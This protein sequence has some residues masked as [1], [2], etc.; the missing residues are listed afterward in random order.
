MK[1]SELIE[2]Y[3]QNKLDEQKMKEVGAE[4]EKHEAISEFLFEE[5]IP[6]F[7]S[8]SEDIVGATANSNL[9]T[10]AKF[11]KMINKSIRAAFIKLGVTVVCLVLALVM[12]VQ[13]VLPKLVSKMYYN[14]EEA[15]TEITKQFDLD[16]AVY[17]ELFVPEQ[18]REETIVKSRGY[19]EYEFAVLQTASDTG[20]FT[21]VS[22]Y[23][24]KNQI[25]FYNPNIIKPF[26]SNAFV[27][28]TSEL[29]DRSQS[30]S[31]QIS[32]NDLEIYSA[33]GTREEAENKIRELDDDKFYNAYVSLDRVMNYEDFVSFLE[34][35]GY[36][37]VVWCA[38]VVT[39]GNTNNIGFFYEQGSGTEIEWDEEKYPHLKLWNIISDEDAMKD[40]DTAKQHFTDMLSYMSE[41]TS[42]CEMMGINADKLSKSKQYIEK[43]GLNIYGFMII[44]QKE[45][46]KELFDNENVF[47][48]YTTAVK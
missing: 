24:D 12:F 17:T 15:V 38:P 22:G 43:N 13:F 4:I 34:D 21:D 10:E 19:G 44:A 42:F 45:E 7:E 16:I 1:Y 27:R 35:T 23:I 3:K 40:T 31:K 9:Q 37:G 29:L 28:E 8:D 26:T 5:D 30:L 20:A 48:I 25:I 2:L 36:D 14:P 18:L 39:G 41:Q 11:V 32:E 46:I 47:T 33:A 6:G